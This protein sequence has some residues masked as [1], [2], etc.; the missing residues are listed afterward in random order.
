[1]NPNGTGTAGS[2]SGSGNSARGPFSGIT[3]QGGRLEGTGAVSA[4]PP[5]RNTLTISTPP[6]A[7]PQLLTAYGMT[8]VS[9]AG[10]GGG[11][12]D[13]GVF[14][15]E[16]VYTVYLDMKNKSGGV[17]PSWTLPYAL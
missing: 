8:V 7:P 5:S 16:Q 17:A 11:L 12:P 15:N 9:N 2:G 3:V 10:S 14:A 1:N 4:A 6:P 13:L